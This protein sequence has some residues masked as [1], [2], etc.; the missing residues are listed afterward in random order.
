MLVSGCEGPVFRGGNA[1][2]NRWPSGF[3]VARSTNGVANS[4]HGTA[5]EVAEGSI[6]YFVE[7]GSVLKSGVEKSVAC[8]NAAV[9][10]RS[11]EEVR[12]TAVTFWRIC[13]PNPWPKILVSS[14]SQCPRDSGI[15][16]EHPALWRAREND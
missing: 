3:P 12:D 11:K 4:R 6:T 9:P 5:V 10:R 7:A 16:R 8:P 13:H 1:T 2:G 15:A 14:R